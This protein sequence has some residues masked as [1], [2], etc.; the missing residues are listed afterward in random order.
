[1]KMKMKM[2]N[3]IKFH[4]KNLYK[5]IMYFAIVALFIYICYKTYKSQQLVIEGMTPDERKEKRLMYEGMS[6]EL[7]ACKDKCKD[8]KNSKERNECKDKCEKTCG[9][10]CYM[11]SDCGDPKK[12]C[13]GL[14]DSELNECMNAVNNCIESAKKCNGA[15]G[16]SGGSSSSSGSYY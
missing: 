13:E 12:Q 9:K 10:P 8:I 14:K 2:K 5:N 1:M 3:P 7:D 6:E 11:V 4:K 15:C 16:I